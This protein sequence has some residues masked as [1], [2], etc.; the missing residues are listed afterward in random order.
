METD[1]RTL[2]LAFLYRSGT[3][4]KFPSTMRLVKIVTRLK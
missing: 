2:G 4:P 1:Y 3:I